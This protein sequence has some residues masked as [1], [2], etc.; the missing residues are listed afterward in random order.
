MAVVD[1]TTDGRLFA[2][3]HR[4]GWEYVEP[5]EIPV[6]DLFGQRPAAEMVPKSDT[7]KYAEK[8]AAARTKLWKRVLIVIVV[9]AV[10]G[11]LT[12]GG[13]VIFGLL[14]AAFWFGPTINRTRKIRSVER[15]HQAEVAAV[16]GR[17]RQAL[18]DWEKAKQ[19]ELRAKAHAEDTT[20]VWFPVASPPEVDRVDVFGGA[21]RGWPHLLAHLVTYVVKGGVPTTV[22]DF[23]Q[24]DVAAPLM[25]LTVGKVPVGGVQIPRDV[26]SL[27]L[28]AD[29]GPDDV[30]EVVTE[31]LRALR[32]NP[33]P[34]LLAQDRRILKQLTEALGGSV[35]PRRLLAGVRVLLGSAS[36]SDDVLHPGE[37]TTLIRAIDQL[38]ANTD[39]VRGQLFF[40]QE[41]L[42][43]LVGGTD[44]DSESPLPLF[45]ETGLVVVATADPGRLRKEFL[46][47]IIFQSTLQRLKAGKFGTGDRILAIAGADAIGTEGLEELDRVAV[48]RG[49]KTVL[50]FEHLRGESL[51]IIGAGQSATVMMRLGNV[52][53]ANAAAQYIGRGYSF[54]LSSLSV[55]VGITNTNGGGTTTG[56]TDTR[57]N[58]DATTTGSTDTRGSSYTSGHAS[59]HG[60]SSGH[61]SSRA[62]SSSRTQSYSTAISDSSQEMNNW[63]RAESENNTETSQRVYEYSIEPT[64]IQ[65]LPETAFILVSGAAAGVSGRPLLVGDCNMAIAL[66]KGVSEL[67]LDLYSYPAPDLQRQVASQGLVVDQV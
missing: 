36:P 25:D 14:L 47:R 60:G 53:E 34:V 2:G 8:N 66:Q 18:G 58:S 46:D 33:D 30:T 42:E 21:A 54:K 55:Q 63:S 41:A 11:A 44:S 62:D 4:W 49:V 29:L 20:A 1:G 67:P 65:T 28:L 57:T 39:A 48:Q 50:L 13:G 9:A 32:Q 52:N 23:S 15:Q 17:H 16:Q 5:P 59:G 7:S 22:L 31:S 40:L 6:S 51:N 56:R 24:R 38:A 10:L 37:V 43:M 12:H 19:D 35:S 64:V 45:P 3:N 27:N 26:D 61:S